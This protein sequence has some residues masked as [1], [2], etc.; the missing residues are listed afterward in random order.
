M[1]NPSLAKSF[2]A[3]RYTP[4]IPIG[5]S[6]C[7][8]G[9]KDARHLNRPGEKYKENGACKLYPKRTIKVETIIDV[10]G[11]EFGCTREE[12]LEKGRKTTLCVI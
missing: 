11:S 6:I 4:G 7:H 3:G 9:R 2:F 5:S 10:V 1:G 12:N 8:I